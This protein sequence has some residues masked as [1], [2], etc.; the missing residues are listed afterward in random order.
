MEM[1]TN[2]LSWFEIPA[3]DFER[4][5][6]FYS[7]IFDFDMPAMPMGGTMMGMFLH[8][9]GKGIGGAIVHGE[10]ATPSA[11][12]TM[13]YLSGGRDLA[14]VL[15]RVEAAG[16]KVLVGKTP[17]TPEYGYYAHFLDT[18][19]NRVGLHSME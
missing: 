9:T 10:G 6:G 16:G 5:R 1:T 15:A 2:A 8:E 14:T 19:G 18:E 11:Q 4:A 12:G 17:I 13:V 7:R 3:A